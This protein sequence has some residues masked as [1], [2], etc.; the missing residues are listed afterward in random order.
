M[1]MN[2][3]NIFVDHRFHN[4]IRR[5]IDLKKVEDGILGHAKTKRILG[6]KGIL[7]IAHLV[8]N[9]VPR[10]LGHDS[11]VKIVGII[12]GHQDLDKIKLQDLFDDSKQVRSDLENS[13]REY[14]SRI[15]HLQNEP[16]TNIKDLESVRAEIE[17]NELKLK[18][19][20]EKLASIPERNTLPQNLFL[21]LTL[22]DLA[23]RGFCLKFDGTGFNERYRLTEKGLALLQNSRQLRDSLYSA[24]DSGESLTDDLILKSWSRMK[25]C[26]KDYP[27]K[28]LI[29]RLVG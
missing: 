21:S 19:V 10:S 24:I 26:L 17:E 29:W 22:G 14:K 3:N 25:Q 11:D 5:L 1:K 13:Q 23:R 4:K 27:L 28:T 16:I 7:N 2:N 15:G 12:T 18:A 6:E 8:R 20:R 9:I